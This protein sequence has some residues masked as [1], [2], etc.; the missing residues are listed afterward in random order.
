MDLGRV[1]P[2]SLDRGREPILG[3]DRDRPVE[4]HPGMTFECVKCRRG[5]R[6]S[7][8]PSVGLLPQA[9]EEL[10]QLQFQLPGR[11]VGLDA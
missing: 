3:C 5:P 8:M 1:A 9:F 6:T 7:Q 4:G 10:H 11:R 2:P